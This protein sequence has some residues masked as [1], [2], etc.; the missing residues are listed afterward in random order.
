M[1]K[2]AL[3]FLLTFIMALASVFAL[4]SCAKQADTYVIKYPEGDNLPSAERPVPS[5]TAPLYTLTLDDCLCE[6]CVD[7][8]N[9]DYFKLDHQ[10]YKGERVTLHDH[11]PDHHLL[12]VLTSRDV[13]LFTYTVYTEEYGPLT[14][15]Y[16]YMPAK[17][18]TISGQ[19]VF[20]DEETVME[21]A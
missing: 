13:E 3:T 21:C 5:P 16:F 4:C 17:D 9:E 2:N 7:V 1:K 14:Y 8:D 18:V 15:Y 10:I 20:K 12:F 11:D 19:V 6:D